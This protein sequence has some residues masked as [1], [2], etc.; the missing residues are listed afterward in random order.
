MKRFLLLLIL[1]LLAAR[2]PM[3]AR[4]QTVREE[5]GGV[6]AG[7]LGTG[8]RPGPVVPIW[9]GG[10]DADSVSYVLRFDS[11]GNLRVVEGNPQTA[12]YRIV[13]GGAIIDDTSSVHCADSSA[14]FFVGDLRHMRLLIRIVGGGPAVRGNV[15]VREHL[16]GVN[17]STSTW[18]IAWRTTRS[19]LAA[20]DSAKFGGLVT[21]G[22][23]ATGSQ[24]IPFEV[25][26]TALNAT[27]GPGNYGS[28]HVVIPLS[29][30]DIGE[31]PLTYISVRVRLV[32]TN[33]ATPRVQVYLLGTPL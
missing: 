10:R 28:N 24:E 12:G 6:G 33:V 27:T 3:E 32:T 19:A 29:H 11:N 20:Q 9:V 21:P 13:S 22:V 16:N 1:F 31:L 18:P 7:D 2:Y 25:A 26:S 15:M 17:D 14:V 8:S 30:L 4:G 5:G 23:T